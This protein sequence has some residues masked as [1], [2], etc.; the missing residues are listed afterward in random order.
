MAAP[1]YPTTPDGNLYEP[2]TTAEI[3]AKG[4]SLEEKC[5]TLPDTWTETDIDTVLLEVFSRAGIHNLNPSPGHYNAAGLLLIKDRMTP[6]LL[7]PMLE[8]LQT[9]Y[10]LGNGLAMGFYPNDDLIAKRKRVIDN[11]S[12]NERGTGGTKRQYRDSDT[13]STASLPNER[14]SQQSYPQAGGKLS[15]SNS[16]PTP[17]AHGNEVKKIRK[18]LNHRLDTKIGRA[19]C[20]ERV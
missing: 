18:V 8:C 9:V 17:L 13:S 3:K 20:R 11:R 1:K 12:E 7:D 10:A 15:Y 16:Y 6:Y 5:S 4:I 19:S 2:L 14:E